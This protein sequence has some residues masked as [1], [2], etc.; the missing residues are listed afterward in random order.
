MI[1]H[2]DFTPGDSGYK[3]GERV[4]GALRKRRVYGAKGLTV[5]NFIDWLEGGRTFDRFDRV[6]KTF[7]GPAL[8]NE[9]DMTPQYLPVFF[10]KLG[11][12]A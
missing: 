12:K 4:I 7:L 1:V 8:H 5:E 11:I 3:L 6:S 10:K 9:L 2:S